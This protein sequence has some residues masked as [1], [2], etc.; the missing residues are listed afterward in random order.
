MFGPVWINV[1]HNSFCINGI[2]W[3]ESRFNVPFG[4]L[5]G[6]TFRFQLLRLWGSNPGMK[7]RK[8]CLPLLW[9]R[10]E[11]GR[12]EKEVGVER[13]KSASKR[14]VCTQFSSTLLFWSVC[15]LPP[16]E[17]I[18]LTFYQLFEKWGEVV[19]NTSEGWSGANLKES[20]VF[21]LLSCVCFPPPP[22]GARKGWIDVRPILVHLAT[23][24]LHWY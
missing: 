15:C 8:V 6:D 1:C 9:R 2:R 17:W 22:S 7:M 18:S 11:R 4:S 14:S 16:A 24:M 19:W 12:V 13:G 21:H 3:L 5:K 10:M 20:R 23:F